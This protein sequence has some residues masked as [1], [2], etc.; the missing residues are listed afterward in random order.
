MTQPI[1]PTI[2]EVSP[3]TATPTYENPSPPKF[4]SSTKSHPSSSSA[5]LS[6]FLAPA[7]LDLLRL[8]EREDRV[9]DA[10]FAVVACRS[11]TK[12]NGNVGGVGGGRN[13]A[14]SCDFLMGV[15]PK[16][17]LCSQY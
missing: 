13:G 15:E 4:P 5:I 12:S 11:W 1:P 14:V 9:R 8:D 2:T 16:N 6:C 7:S 3:P 10:G 17:N